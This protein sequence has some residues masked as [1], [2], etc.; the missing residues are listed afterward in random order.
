[1][2]A[3]FFFKQKTAY[4]M[5]KLLEFRRVLFRSRDDLSAG[6]QVFTA[7]TSGAG[8]ICPAWT[9]GLGFP[10]PTGQRVRAIPQPQKGMAVTIVERSEE[11]RVGK[12]WRVRGW[13]D[14]GSKKRA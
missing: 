7:P 2:S 1:V 10:G 13:A 6:S 8:L 14:D 12:E 4:E 11:R 5:P 3:I 9:R